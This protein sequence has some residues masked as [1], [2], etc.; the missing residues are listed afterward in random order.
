MRPLTEPSLLR[1]LTLSGLLVALPVVLLPEEGKAQLQRFSSSSAATEEVNPIRSLARDKVLLQWRNGDELEGELLAGKETQIRFSNHSFAGPFDLRV[2]QLSGIRFP[3]AA[4]QSKPSNSSLFEITLS[5]GDQLKGTLLELSKEFLRFRCDAIPEPVVIKRVSLVRLT[6]IEES[7]LIAPGLGELTQWISQGRD[8]KASDWYTD[9]RGEMASHQWLGNLFREL[10]LP[11]RVEVSFRVKFPNGSPNFEVGLMRDPHLGPMLETWEN[12]LVLTYLSRFTPVME[13]T[14]E[15]KDVD[16]RLFWDQEAENVTVCAASGEKLASLTK[17]PTGATATRKKPSATS[18]KQGFSILNHTPEIRLLSLNIREWDG[19]PVPIL[20]L[21]KPHL[22]LRNEPV[23]FQVEDVLLPADSDTLRFRG[24]SVPLSDL[25]E[26]IVP[27]AREELS[28]ESVAATTRVAWHSGSTLSG[29]LVTVGP[30]ELAISPPWSNGPVRTSLAGARE[31]R[32]PEKPEPLDFATDTLRK[33]GASG[34]VIR[35]TMRLADG[36]KTGGLIAWQ[37]SGA[38][39][40]V[41]LSPEANVIINRGP[42]GEVDT[43]SPGT[44]SQA[45]LYLENDEILSGTLASI[46]P[47]EVEF[48]SRITGRVK[49]PASQFRALD[50]GTAGRILQGFGDSEWEKVEPVE[51]D[52]LLTP[53]LVTLKN[54]RFGNPSIL[55]G[56][57]IHLETTWKDGNGAM[58]VR[59]FAAGPD[60]SAAST[61]IIIASQGDRLF[62][63]KLN[64]NGAFSFT[65]DQIQITKNKASIDFFVLPESVEIHIDGKNALS[66]PILAE[67]VSGNGIYIKMGGGWQGWNQQESTIEIRDFQ[68]ENSPGNIPRRIVDPRAKKHL[69]TIPRTMRED[70][71]SH[72]LISPNGDLLRGKIVSAGPEE[73]SFLAGEINLKLPTTRIATIVKLTP[74][75]P[76]EKAETSEKST[77]ADQKASPPKT[78]DPFAE[79]NF[80]DLKQYNATISH[81]LVLRDGTRLAL[82]GDSVSENRFVGTSSLL[83]KCTLSL[84]NIREIHCSPPLPAHEAPPLDLVVYTDW[85]TEFAPDPD[86]PKEDGEAESPLAG[87]KA[88]LFELKQLDDSTFKLSENVGKRIIVLDFWASWCGPCVKA[89]PDVQEVVGAFPADLVT[90]CMINQ[91]ETTPIITD[92]LEKRKWKD[93]P[94]ALDFDMKVSQSYGV[95]GIPHTVVI[96]AKG[97]IAWVHTGY[98]A[99]LKRE[100]F[101]A[102]ASL[103]RPQQ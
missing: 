81:R 96:D 86:I 77:D 61:D 100:L 11:T 41:P 30:G 56:D 78:I 91:A 53:T 92:F 90:L 42:S 10:D 35:G 72:L 63:G 37:P 79:E 16:L 45:R 62:I 94:V 43:L 83:G 7:K 5:N 38:T 25:I 87:K 58:T 32:F 14:P 68:I 89:M 17:T 101:E 9:L 18:L 40:A 99:D 33:N 80:A 59:L 60:D 8:R 15:T 88:P 4:N 2:G 51:G 22:L 64:E 24:E 55:L 48:E 73:V 76:L 69:L 1:Y 21:E 50:I 39:R 65:G 12:T 36:G 31:I 20:D 102:I 66:A 84:E 85:Q 29:T 70:P 71:P 103:L 13:L 19:K 6:R 57:R 44:L 23:R 49:L 52:V 26:L 34:T 54:G 98:D 75:R 67:N 3:R 82:S 47:D 27:T 28:D 95:E 97:N 46:T 93:L 74:P